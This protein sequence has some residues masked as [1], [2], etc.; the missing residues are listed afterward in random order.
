[1][2]R[3]ILVR[4]VAPVKRRIHFVYTIFFGVLGAVTTLSNL[5]IGMSLRYTV[6]AIAMAVAGFGLAMAGR[7]DDLAAVSHRVTAW[8]FP[9]VLLPLGWLSSAGLQTP[10]IAYSVLMLVLINY[11]LSGKERVAANAAFVL[12][13]VGLISVHYFRPVIFTEISPL[14]QYLVWAFNVPIVLGL[15]AYTLTFFE[16]A[17]EEERRTA[18]NRALQLEELSV[19]DYLTGL[20]NRQ[21]LDE[22]IAQVERDARRS[23]SRYS[24]LIVDI[25]DFKAFNDAYGHLAGDQVLRKVAAAIRQCIER[26]S[27]RAFR[28]GGEEFLLTLPQTD[29]DGAMRIAERI[30]RRIGE[31]DIRHEHSRAGS[32]ISVSIGIAV[33]DLRTPDAE[34]VMGAADAALYEA[35]RHGRNRTVVRDAAAEES[36]TDG[37]GSSGD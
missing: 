33:G 35:K 16:K 17:H 1:M 4:S 12:L 31:L 5:L 2:S 29:R 10:G 30:H 13:N 27:D 15:T 3:R 18:E 32:R 24:L 7:R 14:Q 34:S 23:G 22:A 11:L 37:G 28:Y 20:L 25:D 21:R 9:F 19:T 36:N 8:L 26:E 6:S